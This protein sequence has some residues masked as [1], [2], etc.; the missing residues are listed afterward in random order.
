MP[1]SNT[2]G[3]KMKNTT[4]FKSAKVAAFA[5]ILAAV[6]LFALIPSA[7]AD[8]IYPDG[9]NIFTAG[10]PIYPTEQQY[11]ML[12]MIKSNL[13]G[14]TG[15]GDGDPENPYIKITVTSQ[16]SATNTVVKVNVPAAK[17]NGSYLPK[18]QMYVVYED[19]NT[20]VPF[21]IDSYRE[22]INNDSTSNFIYMKAN[23]VSGNTSFLVFWNNTSY[24]GVNDG[25]SV[26]MYNT[27]NSTLNQGQYVTLYNGTYNTIESELSYYYNASNYSGR[28][29]GSVPTIRLNNTQNMTITTY[30]ESLENSSTHNYQLEATPQ[31][32]NGSVKTNGSMFIM[33]N[34]WSAGGGPMTNVYATY[35]YSLFASPIN[36][37]RESV[38]FSTTYT[39]RSSGNQTLTKNV[40]Q[41]LNTLSVLASNG[42]YP[43]TAVRYAL[44][45]NST[46]NVTYTVTT[47]Y[48]IPVTS[49]SVNGY[50]TVKTDSEYYF[51][52]TVL[53]ALA[54]QQVTWTTNDSSVATIDSNSGLLTPVSAG[55]VLVTAHATDSSGVTGSMIVYV[56]APYTISTNSPTG[57][58][59]STVP[60]AFAG[61]TVS[62][63]ATPNA[64]YALASVNVTDE[65]GTPV[66]VVNQSFIMPSANVTISATF[67]LVDYHVTVISRTGGTVSAVPTG[68]N[69]GQ[70][71]SLV[72]SPNEGYE[73]SGY[74]AITDG[75]QSVT[76][77]D[78]TFTMPTD[79]V[80]V[81]ATFSA[82]TYNISVDSETEHGSI[83]A[84]P[85]TAKMGQTVTLTS[86]PSAG[87]MLDEWIVTWNGGRVPV[88]NNSF[89]MP[90]S[91]VNVSATFMSTVPMPEI[92][93]RNGTNLTVGDQRI[94][95]TSDAT[96][97]SYLFLWQTSTDNF[98]TIAES[99]FVRADTGFFW[100][101]PEQPGTLQIRMSPSEVQRF[102]YASVN[103]YN[104]LSEFEDLKFDSV[105]NSYMADENH[106][107][108]G[109]DILKAPQDYYD[110]TV[111]PFI[112]WSIL[113]IIVYAALYIS[114]G[115]AFIPA[116]AFSAVGFILV[117]VM[118][119]EL[120]VWARILISIGLFVV[121]AYKYFKQ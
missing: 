82:M 46:P 2:T 68:G 27:A 17:I 21:W 54:K 30:I 19:N 31:I 97:G 45:Y 73:I 62:I 103:I 86:I 23:L 87:Y 9:V 105:F 109:W 116:A 13:L 25:S 77:T 76:V 39:Q 115:G 71:I 80:T 78:N 56:D 55:T 92:E 114:T 50:E 98:D 65:Y 29:Y 7:S 99:G 110:D 37:S 26:F 94:E 15:D 44:I 6:L 40:S 121:P 36:S 85:L 104:R 67:G 95:F 52:A 106:E 75:G 18:K 20:A 38:V 84:N 112:F 22:D 32:I 33:G 107:L 72:P 12:R 113:F 47:N 51:Y 28:G 34:Q 117:N 1:E 11:P 69:A 93:I 66:S 8:V 16:T 89:T 14:A 118:P 10:H 96:N 59:V 119:L 81:T 57:G 43:D 74:S 102:V 42:T 48:T 58:T 4:A 101:H 41:K 83:Y 111:T 35:G 49:I 70:T 3:E 120:S 24:P 108:S 5:A 90:S 53:P 63:V 88:T 64:G 60:H 79:N 61:D 91:D 100:I